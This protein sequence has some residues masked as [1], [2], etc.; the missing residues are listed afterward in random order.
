[1]TGFELSADWK[2]LDKLTV[3]GSYSKTVGKTNLAAG[4]PLD[5]DMTADKI[6][7]QKIY[8]SVDYAFVPNAS[9]MLSSTTYLGRHV[10]AG[11]FSLS[12]ASLQ[13][14]FGGYTLLD[15]SLSYQTKRLGKFTLAAE[16][17]LNRYYIQE[18]SSSSINQVPSGVNAYY[19]S[20]RG[21]MLSLSDSFKW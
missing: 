10:N 8:A 7:P 1:V 21:R 4:Y 9:V 15:G 19:L 2:A 11:V 18:I 3:T 12:D 16:N 13:E 20:G 17:L 6:P 5:V 14:D